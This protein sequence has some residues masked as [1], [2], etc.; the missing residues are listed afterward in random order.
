MGDDYVVLT[1]REQTLARALRGRFRDSRSASPPILFGKIHKDLKINMA[2]FFPLSSR[3]NLFIP[4]RIAG[5]IL[6]ITTAPI[7]ARLDVRHF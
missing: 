1:F 6:E 4:L 5:Q 2:S 7:G 3:Y